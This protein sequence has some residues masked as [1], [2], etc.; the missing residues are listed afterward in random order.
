MPA[1]KKGRATLIAR[2]ST[3]T[4][5]AAAATP[6]RVPA[7]SAAAVSVKPPSVAVSA[8]AGPVHLAARPPIEAALDAFA[9]ELRAALD[10]AVAD[11]A[12]VRAEAAALRAELAQLRQ[13]YEAHTHTYER[14]T[15]GGGGHQ[16]IELRFLQGYIDSEQSAFKNFGIWSHGKSTSDTPP[17]QQTTGPSA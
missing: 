15:M 10:R 1:R 5:R 13:R 11:V 16:W 3:V 12:A 4:V 8:G 14:S 9:R 7:A 2:T 6:T 17:E